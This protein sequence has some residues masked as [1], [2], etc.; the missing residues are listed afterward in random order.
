MADSKVYEANHLLPAIM[1]KACALMAIV[2]HCEPCLFWKDPNQNY[3]T[4]WYGVFS[5]IPHVW[6]VDFNL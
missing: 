2:H 4:Y 6:L 1:N 3:K 5:T